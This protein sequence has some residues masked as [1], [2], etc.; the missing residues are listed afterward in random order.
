MDVKGCL[1]PL[2]LLLELSQ[3]GLVQ[4]VETNGSGFGFVPFALGFMFA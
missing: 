4:L 3:A 2:A 1:L